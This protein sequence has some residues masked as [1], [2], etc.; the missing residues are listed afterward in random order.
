MDEFDE[1]LAPIHGKTSSKIGR[2]FL[3]DSHHFQSSIDLIN[4]CKLQFSE[5]HLFEAHDEI[6]FGIMFPIM[7]PN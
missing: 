2:D 3:H 4:V 5:H 6:H 7:K 1:S